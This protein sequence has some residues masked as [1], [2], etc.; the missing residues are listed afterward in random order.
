ME[1]PGEGAAQA[2][3]HTLLSL[4]L[5]A[6]ILA[7]GTGIAAPAL[8]VY[9]RSFDISFGLASLVVIV[10]LL[11]S[12]VST[13]PTGYLIDRVG[14]RRVVLAGPLLTA[15]ASF[16]V[17][18]AHSFPELLLYRF[19]GGCGSQM[20]MLARLAII[21][22]TG[23][24]HRGRQ[25]T[26]MFGMDAIG[27]LLGPALGG[28][29]AAG[30]GITVPFILHGLVALLALI[31]SVSLVPE[32]RPRARFSPAGAS[33]P[34]SRAARVAWAEFLARPLLI[35]LAAQLFSS[36][37]RG[38]LFSG[39]LDL[40][41]VY[42]YAVGPETIGLL[43]AVGS[44]LG[45][46]LTFASGHLMDRFGRKATVV[47]GLAALGA[48]LSFLAL[49]AYSRW[50]FWTYVVGFLWV[51][52]ALSTT[53]GSM[54][55]LASDVAPA[56]A[57]GQFFGLWRFIGEIGTFVSPVAFAGLSEWLGFAA[58]FLF[59]SATGVSAALLLGTQVRETLFRREAPAT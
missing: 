20:W 30:W 11:G 34:E 2:S 39:T 28:V 40:Y 8:P 15:L 59:L 29:V 37:T 16:L 6:F 47:P 7:L 46:P 57:R 22:D 58:S 44:A 1:R 32:T 27:R 13:I 19:L 38:S 36:L 12:L 14:R 10:Y 23:G 35:L 4:H 9:A 56:H 5:P 54:Q 3:R 18:T 24:E 42:A 26:G 25:I 49:T 45:I 50:P 52:L 51:R 53:S 41:A 17:A 21:A 55:V 31:P 43:S 48:G 33:G